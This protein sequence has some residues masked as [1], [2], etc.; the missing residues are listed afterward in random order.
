L[1]SNKLAEEKIDSPW[2]EAISKPQIPV[3]CH[4]ERSEESSNLNSSKS[5]APFRMTEK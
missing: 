1:S 2:L 5:F 3:F 4:S